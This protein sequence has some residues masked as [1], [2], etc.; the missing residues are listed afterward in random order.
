MNPASQPRSRASHPSAPPEPP[1]GIRRP[2]WR[3]T[4]LALPVLALAACNSVGKPLPEL[5][6]AINA[7]YEAERMGILPGDVLLV[8]FSER[9]DWDQEALVRPDGTASFLQLGE[10]R[11]GGLSIVELEQRLTT[12]YAAVIQQYELTVSLKEIGSRKISVLG[13]VEEPGIYPMTGGRMTLLEAFS[14][15][16]GLDEARGN[17]KDVYLVRWLPSEGRQ[18]SWHVDART[19]Y[20]A[21]AEP[22]L[23]QPFDLV[24]VPLKT[25]VHVNV[26][27]DQYIRQ[28]IPFPYLFPPI[29]Y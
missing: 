22:V 21:D 3:R 1:R 23:L 18:Q 16:G 10:L 9:S 20:W 12:A 17:L 5:A 13:A 2:R 24:Y 19:E 14:A 6:P 29:Q 27:I 7:A 26:W 8:R 28:M 4:L 15:A 25:V 11:V